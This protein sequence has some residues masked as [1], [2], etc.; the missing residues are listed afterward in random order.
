MFISFEGIDFCGKTTQI[1]LLKEYLNSINIE[2]TI[3]REPGGTLISEKIREILLDKNNDICDNT[4][5]FLFLAARMQ[6][7]HEKIKPNLENNWIIADRYIDSTVAYQGYGKGYNIDIINKIHDNFLIKPD[8]T[9]YLSMDT[10][11]MIKRQN[12][13]NERDIDRMESNDISFFNKVIDGYRNEWMSTSRI[14]NISAK[15][16]V[17][18]IHNEIIRNIHERQKNK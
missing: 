18:D 12:K 13:Q 4:E 17:E 11:E 9:F 5:L 10:D 3:I 6:V 15:L 14:I 1:K 8:I 7:F 2:P 16:K